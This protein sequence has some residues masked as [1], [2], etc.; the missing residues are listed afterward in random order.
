MRILRFLTGRCVA[1]SS[2]LAALA[3]GAAAAEPALHVVTSIPPLAM[4][5]SEVG[6]GRVAARSI[7][8]PGADPHTFEPKPS[9][10]RAIAEADVVVVLGSPIDSWIGKA[11]SP[12]SKAVVVRLDEHGE[13]AGGHGE[14][15]DDPHVW[16]DP[17]W[18]RDR[19]LPPLHRALAEADPSGAPQY[20]AAMR[21]VAERM[22]ELDEDI[23]TAFSGAVTRSFLAWHP[24]WEAF[25]GRYAL[26]SV[27]SVGEVSGREPSVRA[28][29]EA[30]RAARAASVR[31][32][33]VEPQVDARQARVLADE[34]G[35]AVLTVDPLGDPASLERST[36]RLLMLYNANAFARALGVLKPN[37]DDGATSGAASQSTTSR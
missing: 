3:S 11:I 32:V 8:P 5:V 15:H 34:L 26:H 25:A 4:I 28:M 21:T 35:V 16:L 14:D 36:Y 31:A 37:G 27:G 33:L 1:A 19:A 29:I 23:R 30:I 2:L 17:L 18:V 24:A 6:A 12:S 10:G 7:L 20:G 9:D 13:H 22:T